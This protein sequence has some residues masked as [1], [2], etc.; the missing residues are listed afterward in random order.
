MKKIVT[1]VSLCCGALSINSYA[2]QPTN[3][4]VRAAM[5]KQGF[6][7]EKGANLLPAIKIVAPHDLNTLWVSAPN[8]DKPQPSYRDRIDEL[9]QLDRVAP[10]VYK[11]SASN[12]NPDSSVLRKNIADIHLAYAFTP[13]PSA[14][15]EKPYG[16]AACGTFNNG[17]TGITEFFQKQDVGTCAYTENNFALSHA[18]AHVNEAVVRYDV[19]GKHTT[20][21]VEGDKDAGYLYT[22]AWIDSKYF[23]T[24]ECASKQRDENMAERVIAMAKRI[25]NP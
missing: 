2:T 23:R 21:H 11:A 22:V 16:F 14:E 17:W 3:D 6:T 10:E 7:L 8:T 1:V 19:N 4:V 18:A 5:Q 12:H 25:D 13:A 20:V 9:S 24:L 15:A